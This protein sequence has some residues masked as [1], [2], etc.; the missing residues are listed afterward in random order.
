MARSRWIS[1][2]GPTHDG[3]VIDDYTSLEVYLVTGIVFVLGFSLSVVLSTLAHHETM[4]WL[5][6]ALTLIIVAATFFGLRAW[7]LRRR[8]TKAKQQAER[9]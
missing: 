9:R 2:E 3:I 5:G 4:V 7:E 1:R 8:K 6:W